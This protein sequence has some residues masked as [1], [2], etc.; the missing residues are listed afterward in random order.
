MN[1]EAPV[2]TIAISRVAAV[3]RIVGTIRVVSVIPDEVKNDIIIK[4]K[5]INKS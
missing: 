2:T 3:L 1:A 4:N 5:L